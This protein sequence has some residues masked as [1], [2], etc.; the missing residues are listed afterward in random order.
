M[1]VAEFFDLFLEELQQTPSL[2]NYY[3]FLGTPSSF[4]FR[5]SYFCQRLQYIADNITDRN[6]AIW[7]CGCGFGTTA[8]FLAMN[9]FK[10]HGTTLEFYYKEIEGRKKYWDKFGDTSLFTADYENL[11]DAPVKP[12]A[13]DAI[14]I[15]DTLHHLEPLQDALRIFNQTLTPNGR[16]VIVEEN[17][18]NIIQNLKLYKQRGNK[19]IIEIYDERLQKNILIGNENIRSLSSWKKELSQ[20]G[21]HIPAD[22]VQYVRLY[23]P[24]FFKN[25]NTEE[26]LKK[27]QQL[28]RKNGF[29]RENFFFGLNYTATKVSATKSNHAHKQEMATRQHS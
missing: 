1:T 29:L 19:R 22:S 15:Q 14:I 3:K 7:D 17:G 9:G 10:V 18:N 2:Q 21:F 16:L 23:L 28:W 11:F 4:E 20:A 6:E 24:F 13:Y 12:A 26:L 5:K 8:L 25:G 27:E